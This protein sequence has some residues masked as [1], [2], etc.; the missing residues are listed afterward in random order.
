MAE[1]LAF[2]K[3]FSYNFPLLCDTTRDLGMK[4]GACDDVKA[5]N[6][7]RISYVI[8]PDQKVIEA[9]AKVDAKNHPVDLLGRL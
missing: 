6:A 2:A 1:N 7:K 9:I 5:G 4:Y 8:G 3:K